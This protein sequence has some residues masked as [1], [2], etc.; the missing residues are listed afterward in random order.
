MS[1]PERDPD[2]LPAEPPP[3]PGYIRHLD[4]V[5]ALVGGWVALS[6]L[7]LANLGEPGTWNNVLIGTAIFLAAGYNYYRRMNDLPVSVGAATFVGLLG[8]W[9]I[10]SPA[11]LDVPAVAFWSTL[12][13]GLFVAVASG[14]IAHVGRERRPVELGGEESRADRP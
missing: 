9:L 8:L 2:T 13:S 6:G 11:L 10:V 5:V 1:D 12:V 14:V 3:P 4:A 7:A